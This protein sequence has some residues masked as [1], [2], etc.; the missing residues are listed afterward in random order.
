MSQRLLLIAATMCM[1]RA[2][3]G[4]AGE[5]ITV[6]LKT[7]PAKTFLTHRQ[8]IK[9]LDD[10]GPI[11]WTIVPRM[12]KLLKTLGYDPI[13]P[14]EFHVSFEGDNILDLD[15]ARNAA[16]WL[17]I[18]AAVNTPPE[19][20][21]KFQ[22]SHSGQYKC[23]SLAFKGSPLDS[24]EHWAKLYQEAKIR[25]FIASGENREI[26]L[27]RDGYDTATYVTELQLGV[28]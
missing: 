25:K 26:G 18:A 28:K 4:A 1:C 5:P 10:V 27:I 17:E 12:K 13:P 3:S 14:I 7:V 21:G 15:V 22:I 2:Q 11:E 20:P 19:D 8:P 23:L 16:R 24:G 9:T 6:Q